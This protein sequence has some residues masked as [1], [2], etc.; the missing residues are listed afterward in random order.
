MSSPASCPAP[1]L[2]RVWHAHVDVLARDSARRDRAVRWLDERGR[3]RY[4]RYRHD[5]DREMFLLGRVM[6]RTLVGR[7]MGRPPDAW[8]WHEGPRGRPEVAE[9]NAT[10]RFNLAHSAGLV[11]CVLADGRDV[12]VDL[13]DRARRPL[14]P[15]VVRRYCAPAE[16]AD[17]DAQGDGGWHDRFLTYWTLKEAYLKARGLGI[18]LP[19]AEIALSLGPSPAIGFLHSLAGADARWAFHVSA[20]TPRHLLA[21]AAHTGPGPVAFDVRPFPDDWL[22]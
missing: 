17:I 4:A 16:V 20:P 10:V 21:A 15:Q 7:T 13:E 12:G 18:A 14:D 8:R 6:A 5:E 1:A 3:A 11:A 19:L 2:V 9:P 22:P